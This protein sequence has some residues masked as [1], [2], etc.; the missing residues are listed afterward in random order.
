MRTW[1]AGDAK[2]LP[3]SD[4]EAAAYV[5]KHPRFAELQ[6]HQSRLKALAAARAVRLGEQPADAH[7]RAAP[8]P[9]LLGFHGSRSSW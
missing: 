9:S 5:Q 3:Q 6:C 1:L 2:A 4:A 8:Q 7:T